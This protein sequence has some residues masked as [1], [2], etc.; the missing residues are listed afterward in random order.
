[1]DQDKIEA[2]GIWVVR[3]LAVFGFLVGAYIG[4]N[5]LMGA[6]VIIGVVSILFF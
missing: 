2:I 3:A 1:M 4:N 5:D 6:S